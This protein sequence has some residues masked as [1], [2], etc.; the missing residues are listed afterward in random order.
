MQVHA[1]G[2]AQRVGSLSTDP[3]PEGMSGSARAQSLGARDPFADTAS[4]SGRRGLLT[5]IALLLTAIVGLLGYSALATLKRPCRA[6]TAEMR[7]SPIPTI[8][9]PASAAPS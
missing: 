9:P 7:R 1:P 8:R 2:P 5:I 3:S 6:G 4:A